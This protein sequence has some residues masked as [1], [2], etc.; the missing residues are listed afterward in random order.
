M[1]GTGDNGASETSSD[2]TADENSNDE[3]ESQTE[4]ERKKDAA[5][6][7]LHERGYPGVQVASPPSKGVIP[8]LQTQTSHQRR[9]QETKYGTVIYTI[10]DSN[11]GQ[12]SRVETGQSRQ[13]TSSSLQ[14][15]RFQIHKRLR[16]TKGRHSSS[17]RKSYSA[18]RT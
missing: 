13:V 16:D 3:E 4:L 2:N 5:V 9:F 15:E 12:T 6:A 7:P 1:S 17:P 11:T 14:A 10:A 18:E 8:G